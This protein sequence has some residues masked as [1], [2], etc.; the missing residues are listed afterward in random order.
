MNSSNS[1]KVGIEEFAFYAHVGFDYLELPLGEIML[2]QDEEYSYLRQELKKS[3][4]PCLAC[5]NFIHGGIRITGKDFNIAKVKKYCEDAITRAA[6]LGAE[7]IVFGSSKARNIPIGFSREKA[8]EQIDET[9]SIIGSI[10]QNNG[11]IIAI[12]QHNPS[13]GNVYNSYIEV[14]E[15]AFRARHPNIKC[16]IDNYHLWVTLETTDVFVGMGEM[17]GHMHISALLERNMPL[18]ENE[19]E[20]KDFFKVLKQEKY[21]KLMSI[22]GFSKNLVGD[23][24]RALDLLRRL[25]HVS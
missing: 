8:Y 6:D 9:L 22:E 13:E 20:Y 1:N 15:A 23:A 21:D 14:R 16:N 2:L 17:L 5:N 10:A 24:V 19:L 4:I 11:V 3:G 7:V 12:E 25:W 18:N